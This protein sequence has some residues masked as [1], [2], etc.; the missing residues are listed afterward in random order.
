MVAVDA[1]KKAG[2]KDP[3]RKMVRETEAAIVRPDTLV[4]AALAR[5][6]EEVERTF[7]NR[8]EW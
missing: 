8:W 3:S 4:D 5:Q 2:R 1:K 6:V 7:S